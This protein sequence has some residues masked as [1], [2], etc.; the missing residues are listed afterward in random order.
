MLQI[1]TAEGV[2]LDLSTDAEFVIEMNQPLLSESRAVTPFSTAISFPATATNREVFGWYPVRY[3]IPSVLTVPASVYF[4]GLH[5]VSGFLKFDSIDGGKLQYTFSSAFTDL[6]EEI[7]YEKTGIPLDDAIE[8]GEVSL[9]LIVNENAVAEHIYSNNRS[10]EPVAPEVKFRNYYGYDSEGATSWPV[11]CP[12][13][14]ISA[15]LKHV[16]G[17]AHANSAVYGFLDTLSILFRSA[18]VIIA[19]V[20]MMGGPMFDAGNRNAPMV[21]YGK[22]LAECM[23]MVCGAVYTRSGKTSLLNAAEI[24]GDSVDATDYS[25]KVSDIYYA[26]VEPAQ[27]YKFGFLD[28]ADTFTADTLTGQ[29]GN[30]EDDV[31]T[32]DDLFSVESARWTTKAF[33]VRDVGDVI[34]RRIVNDSSI[35]GTG[36]DS[37]L[38]DADVTW[39]NDKMAGTGTGKSEIFDATVNAHLPKVVPV[40]IRR[41]GQPDRLSRMLAPVVPAQAADADRSEDLYIGIVSQV[42]GYPC[43]FGRGDW[44]YTADRT[45]RHDTGAPAL[46][47][48]ALYERFHKEFARWISRDRVRV[49]CTMDMSALD[50]ASVDLAKPVYFAGRRWLISRISA[51]FRALGN[52]FETEGEFITI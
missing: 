38:I 46:R 27:G 1:K 29:G 14:S 6:D 25:S 8:G 39:Q 5:V 49:R 18:P 28:D 50:L 35:G 17:E 34:A 9:P 36:D 7:S 19:G 13:V 37:A 32:Y 42:A 4:C 52:T 43:Q 24:L 10:I 30:S 16:I 2:A 47:T 45:L 15:I 33:R 23:K 41:F 3:S 31:Q 44:Y 11:S 26:E 21:T 40:S 20:K 48:E 12:A 51:T 22:L